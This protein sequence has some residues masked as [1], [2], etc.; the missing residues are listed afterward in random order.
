MATMRPRWHRAPL[1][2]FWRATLLQSNQ[3]WAS[4]RQGEMHSPFYWSLHG[5]QGNCCARPLA[6]RWA[7][8]KHSILS[9]GASRNLGKL[10]NHTICYFISSTHWIP[11]QQRLP[12]EAPALLATPAWSPSPSVTSKST[13]KSQSSLVTGQAQPSS[14]WL[15]SWGAAVCS[16]VSQT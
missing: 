5:G 7:K 10:E 4:I 12:Q 1:D 15:P 3:A 16:K 13:P 9:Q 2:F 14:G 6:S 8:C 11:K